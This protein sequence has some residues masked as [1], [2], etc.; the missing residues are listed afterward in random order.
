MKQN[1]FKN[2]ILILPVVS[3]WYV[4]LFLTVLLWYPA[5]LSAIEWREH[6]LNFSILYIVWFII[7][8][9]YSLLDFQV[10]HNARK[11]ISRIIGAIVLCVIVAI[12]YFYFQP[13]LLLTP[14]RFLLV[15]IL[16]SS[17]GI[18]I[19]YWILHRISPKVGQRVIYSHETLGDDSNIKK[20]IADHGYSGLKYAGFLNHQNLEGTMDLGITVILPTHS[21]LDDTTQQELFSLRRNGVRFVDYFDLYES[22]TRTINLSALSELWFIQSIDYSSHELYSL[23]KRLID[24]ILG[25]LG[26]ILFLVSF[27]FIATMI[28]ITSRGPVFFKQPRAGLFGNAFNLYKYRTMTI[29]S[30]S[31]EWAGSG[32]KVTLVGKFLRA[33]RLDELPQSLNILAGNM[34]IVGPRP[35]Q[36]GIVELM[37]E[38]IPYYDERHIVK[39][40]LTGWAQLHVYAASVEETKRKLQYDL[41][42]IKHRSLLFDLEIILK[43]AY[44]ILTFK[45]Q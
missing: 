32:Q 37:R 28:K 9:V 30:A 22:L 34:S 25:L 24:I 29:D 23:V 6:V 39:P 2:L 43:T 16:I 12:I 38:Q 18:L 21:L 5:G 42:Y 8:F 26:T 13:Q 19:W 45:G 17:I 33:T 27:P 3:F 41:Y 15:H 35:E 7:F 31:N 10:L 44:N 11:M 20:L 4:G 14:R 36:V 1:S 40:G